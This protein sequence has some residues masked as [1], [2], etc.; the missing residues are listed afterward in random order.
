MATSYTL[1][2]TPSET[3]LILV[4]AIGTLEL[5]P[6]TRRDYLHRRRP[7][8]E[9]ESPGAITVAEKRRE[10]FAKWLEEAQSGTSSRADGG[11]D[12]VAMESA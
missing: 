4:L 2:P 8:P 6:S 3:S 11:D 7:A 5:T 12:D 10:R 9:P 1:S